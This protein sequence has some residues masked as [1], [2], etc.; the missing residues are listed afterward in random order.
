MPLEMKCRYDSSH[1][2]FS[3]PRLLTTH[4]KQEHA[5]VFVEVVHP[6]RHCKVC[7]SALK[8]SSIGQHMRGKHGQ[9]PPF[10]MFLHPIGWTPGQREQTEQH[11][12]TGTYSA[13]DRDRSAQLC[14]CDICGSTMRR[15]SLAKH[16]ERMHGS[17]RWTVHHTIIDELQQHE[18]THETAIERVEHVQQFGH[19]H[20]DSQWS[21]DDIVLPVIEQLASPLGLVPVQSLGALFV[22]RDAT[23]QMLRDVTRTS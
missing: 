22:W 19:H 6:V 11:T 14:R 21:V 4:Y 13:R 1:G 18:Q 17:E 15:G 5:D 20:D 8:P 7:E 12:S 9:E 10:A 2:T 3:S 23:V 16:F